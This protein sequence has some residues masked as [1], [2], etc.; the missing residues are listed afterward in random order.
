MEQ[1]VIF[2]LYNPN[3]FFQEKKLMVY[4]LSVLHDYNISFNKV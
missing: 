1:E 3:A 2:L 4:I